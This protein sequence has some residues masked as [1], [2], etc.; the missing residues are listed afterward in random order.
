MSEF[1]VNQCI[2]HKKTFDEVKAYAE[3]NG[4]TTVEEL[5]AEEFCSNSCRMCKPYIELMFETGE[6]A[7]KPGAYYGRK[8]AG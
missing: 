6:T 3:E 8:S 2:C 4:Y 5:Q 7:F 1:L